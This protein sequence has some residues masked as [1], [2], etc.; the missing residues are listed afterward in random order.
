MYQA[1][2][3]ALLTRMTTMMSV[4][5][6][7]SGPTG[8]TDAAREPVTTTSADQ[9]MWEKVAEAFVAWRDGSASADSLVRLMSPVLWHVARACRLSED[10]ASEVVQDVWLAL[11]RHRDSIAN[12]RAVASW[13]ITATRREAWQVRRKATEAARREE[14]VVE[15]WAWDQVAPPSPAAEDIAVEHEAALSLWRAVATLPERCQRLLR[16]IAFSERPDYAQL[17]VHL[18]MPIGSIGPTRGRCLGKLR[19][20]LD[21]VSVTSAAIDLPDPGGIGSPAATFGSMNPR[22]TSA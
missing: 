19:A 17:S 13:L 7:H 3:G 11:V 16:V 12:P 4:G 2:A 6:D 21:A 5:D 9:S 22:E 15:E 10:E 1:E 14:A 8:G 20:A 18:E